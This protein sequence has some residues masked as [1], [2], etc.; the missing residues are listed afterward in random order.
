MGERSEYPVSIVF[1]GRKLSRIIIDPHYRKKHADSMTDELILE[2]VRTL[3]G[4]NYLPG[5]IQEGFEFFKIEPVCWKG[6]SYRL[7][8]SLQAGEDFL[9]VVNAFRVEA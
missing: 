9:G 7:I 2:L 3:D 4:Q 5:S 1:N 6:K 8:L